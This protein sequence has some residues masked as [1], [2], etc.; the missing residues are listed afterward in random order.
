M[1][2][3]AILP[4]LS[5]RSLYCK[6][7][8]SKLAQSIIGTGNSSSAFFLCL[9]DMKSDIINTEDNNTVYIP[10]IVTT[11]IVGSG[12]LAI[13]P[14]ISEPNIACTFTLSQ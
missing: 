4:R 1:R 12:R 5:A 9:L 10:V 6:W 13:T 3:D 11:T 7:S 8:R 14:I 2:L